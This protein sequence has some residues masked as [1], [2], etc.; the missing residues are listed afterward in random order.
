MKNLAIRAAAAI[1][2]NSSVRQPD[3]SLSR[4]F[5]ILGEVTTAFAVRR[6]VR[7]LVL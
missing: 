4:A 2:P 3:S 5:K 6:G 1:R 7:S